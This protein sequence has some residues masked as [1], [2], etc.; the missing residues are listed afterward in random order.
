MIDFK[1][2][3]IP[4][5]DDQIVVL[6]G[7]PPT[8]IPMAVQMLEF[9][10][11]WYHWLNAVWRFMLSIRAFPRLVQQADLTKLAKQ[12]S[13]AQAGI[14]VWVATYNHILRWTG[15][16]WSYAPGDN[17]AAYLVEFLTAPSG[18]GWLQ[19]DG[20]TTDFLNSDGTLGIQNLPTAPGIYFRR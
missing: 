14:Q 9:A 5:V 18:E 16:V 12:F 19:C 20:S 4:N 15:S 1:V 10:V 7:E 8:D 2:P 17:G 13:Q 6:P 3:P 11:H